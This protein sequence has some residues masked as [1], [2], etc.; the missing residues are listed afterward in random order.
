MEENPCQWK[1]AKKSAVKGK[2]SAD[3]GR[4]MRKTWTA[5]AE[6]ACMPRRA[7][8]FR[9]QG[10]IHSAQTEY[11]IEKTPPLSMDKGGVSLKKKTPSRTIRS[12][13]RRGAEE[14]TWTPTSVDTRTSNVPVYLFQHFRK[15]HF[16]CVVY[17]NDSHL[18]C[19]QHFSDFTKSRFSNFLTEKQ[20]A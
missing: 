10:T 5:V 11:F 6:R 4:K 18:V 1:T 19:Q 13:R 7:V 2:K 20:S 14:E 3:G 9:P 12:P 8:S 17:Y 15:K 16:Q